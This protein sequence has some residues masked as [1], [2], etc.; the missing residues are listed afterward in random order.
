MAR[1]AIVARSD[2]Y[3]AE[4]R[5][6][7]RHGCVAWMREAVS[8][9][10]LSD[11]RSEAIGV[12]TDVTEQRAAEDALRASEEQRTLLMQRILNVQ[13]D[14][15]ARIAW[16]LHDQVGQELSAVL[17]GLRV[18]EAAAHLED[19]TSQAHDLRARTSSTLEDIRKIAVDMRPGSLDELGLAVVLGR[20]TEAAAESAGLA[21]TFRTHNDHGIRLTPQAELVLYRVTHAAVANVVRH[22]Q[23]AALAVVLR[24]EPDQVSIL[25]EDDGVGFDVDATMAGPPERRFGL[26]A[27]AERLKMIDGQVTIESTLGEGSVVLIEV[28]LPPAAEETA[29]AQDDLT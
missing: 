17:I 13:E 7:D 26:L 28:K 27:M 11:E 6:V 29:A 2:G 22:A 19:A 14:E 3:E 18:I 4:Y 24:I 25:V 20:E 10:R 21:A 9:M 1:D 15:R 5:V 8:V 16:E 12:I 23:A